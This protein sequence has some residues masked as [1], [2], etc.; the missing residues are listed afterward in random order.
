MEELYKDLQSNRL[1]VKEINLERIE[2]LLQEAETAAGV[3]GTQTQLNSVAISR[4]Q[5][6]DLKVMVKGKMLSTY[7]DQK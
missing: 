2:E 4:R 7:F 3:L 5:F 6:D 1:D